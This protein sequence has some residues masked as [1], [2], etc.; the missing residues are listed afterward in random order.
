MV[1]LA[2]VVNVVMLFVGFVFIVTSLER[3]YLPSSWGYFKPT[4]V[5]IC[6][7][8]GTFGV[9]FTLFLLFCRF[10]PMVAIAEVKSVLPAAHPHDHAEDAGHA[11]ASGE[12]THVG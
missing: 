4:L 1:G 2:I 3:T 10:L 5:D 6:T 9:F 7:F 8:A 11:K 12:V